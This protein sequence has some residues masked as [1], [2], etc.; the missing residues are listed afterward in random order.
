M[1]RAERQ[2]TKEIYRTMP[3]RFLNVLE[4]NIKII[5]GFIVAATG[6]FIVYVDNVIIGLRAVLLFVSIIAGCLAGYKAWLDIQKIKKSE[7]SKKRE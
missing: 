4:N 2:A 1:Y 6:N 7:K 3:H 5:S